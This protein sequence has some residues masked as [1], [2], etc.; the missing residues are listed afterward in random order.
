MQWLQVSRSRPVK[1]KNGIS[2]KA[3]QPRQDQTY[4][5][6]NNPNEQIGNTIDSPKIE[7]AEYD[8]SGDRMEL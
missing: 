8:T 6:S 5:V 3:N 7:I 4:H 2:P 1:D